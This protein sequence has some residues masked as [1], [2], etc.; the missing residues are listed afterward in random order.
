MAVPLRLPGYGSFDAARLARHHEQ[1]ADMTRRST[2]VLVLVGVLALWTSGAMHPTLIE[3]RERHALTASGDSLENAPPLLVFSTVALGGFR[4]LIADIMWLRA[5]HLQ[6]KGAYF[7]LVQLADFITKLQPRFAEVWTYHAWN[8]TYNV[9][10]VC[11]RPEDRWRWI[12]HGIRLLRDEGAIYNPNNSSML[13]E[14]ARI[15]QHKIGRAYDSSHLF[16]KIR[17]ADEMQRILGPSM[18]EQLRALEQAPIQ[19]R[20]L[21]DH[22]LDADRMRRLTVRYGLLDWRSPDTVALYWADRAG[23]IA[24]AH[25]QSYAG[26]TILHALNYIMRQGQVHYDPDTEIYGRAPNV[27]VIPG[28]LRML[29]EKAQR[30]RSPSDYALLKSVMAT[31]ILSLHQANDI[32]QAREVYKRLSALLAPTGQPVTTY[33]T[34]LVR[35]FM[36]TSDEIRPEALERSVAQCLFTRLFWH[37][38]GVP[39]YAGGFESLARVLHAEYLGMPGPAAMPRASFEE[40]EQRALTRA[41]AELPAALAAK[42]R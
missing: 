23:E 34:V 8:L 24:T 2:A 31:A 42:L 30:D 7:E 29:E 14:I 38:A 5:S 18:E 9:S 4:G 25:E 21:R 20:L 10:F 39:R 27:N 1:G 36:R 13:L 16:Y 28:I 37:C 17:L 35:Q 40:L 15:Y 3:A 41:R 19:A 12:Q 6:E 22:N 32:Y 26:R 11:P 33:K